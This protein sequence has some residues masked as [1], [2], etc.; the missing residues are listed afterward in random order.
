[1]PRLCPFAHLLSSLYADSMDP[2]TFRRICISGITLMTGYSRSMQ[3]VYTSIHPAG[4]VLIASVLQGRR[5][6]VCV[7]LIRPIRTD[8]NLKPYQGFGFVAY[9]I[10]HGW[11][12]A[13]PDRFFWQLFGPPQYYLVGVPFAQFLNSDTNHCAY[14][15]VKVSLYANF[16]RIHSSDGI[17]YKSQSTY[18]SIPWLPFWT[19]CDPYVYQVIIILVVQRHAVFRHFVVRL[20]SDVAYVASI[21]CECGNVRIWLWCAS[22]DWD[23]SLV[24]ANHTKIWAYTLVR[25][26]IRYPFFL[27]KNLLGRSLF[28][29]PDMASVVLPWYLLS[30]S[31]LG[32]V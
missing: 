23:S 1:M 3:W 21:Q 19:T 26:T 17:R 11:N 29:W 2:Q 10:Y 13:L 4:H 24:S 12:V 28:S 8:P 18:V 22:W 5:P 32:S 16:V 30:Q 7:S 31:D 14:R 20:T 27:V 9:G 15:S 6:L 25:W